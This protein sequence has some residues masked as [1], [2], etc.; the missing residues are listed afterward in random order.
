M[1]ILIERDLPA[2]QAGSESLAAERGLVRRSA[3][4]ERLSAVGPGNVIL[5]CAPAGSGKTLLVRSWAQAEGLSDRM[6]WVQVERGERDG[7]RFW[8]SVIDALARAVKEVRRVEP[9]PSFG[10]EAVVG[11]LGDDLGSL[12]EPALLV[13]DDLHE[14]QS[15][16]ALRWLELILS[17][18]TPLLR[19][20]LASREDPR[21]GLH[22]LRLAGE[23]LELR[24]P[25]LRFSLEETAEL[26]R[27]TGVTLSDGGLALLFERTEGWA[28]GLRLAA[29]LLT[30]H[31]DPERFVTEFSGSERTVAGYLVAEVLE[32]QPAD[33]REMLLRTSILERVSGSLADYLT[34][35]SGAERTLQALE[36]ANAFVTSLD[37]GRTWFR[38]HHLFSDLLQLELRRVAPASVGSLHRAAA[39]W[40]A[41]EGHIVEAIRHAQRARDWPFASRLLVDHHLDL[42]LDGRGG[43]VCGLLTAFPEDVVAADAELALVFATA[44]LV[45]QELEQSAGYVDLARRQVDSVQQE[46]RPRFDVLLALMTLV[47]ARWHG[48]IE[49]VQGSIRGLE[50]A[51]AALPGGERAMS[52][53][54]RSVARQNLGIAELWSARLDDARQNLEQA[55][56]LARRARRP[57]LEIPCLGHLGIAGPW[58]GLTLSEGLQLSE[59]AVRIT[60]AH[61]WSED[62]VIETA[63]A[64]GALA[65]L[66]LGRFDDVE[67]WLERAERSLHPEGEPGTELLLHHARG[68][69]RLAQG[70][71]EDALATFRA[72]ERT[73]ALLVD[74]HPFTVRTQA[75][76]LYTQAR[77]GQLAAAR[78][79]LADISEEDR[80]NAHFRIAAAVIHLADQEPE[81]A[82]DV[83]GPVIEGRVPTHHRPSAATEA[84]WLQAIA[85][86]QSGDPR[87]AEASLEQALD[88]AEPEGIVLPFI[89]APE[90]ELLERLPR[91]RTAH[92][93]L[94]RTIIGLLAGSSAPRRSEPHTLLEDLS[95]AE[96]R[97]V[98]YLPSNL[99]APEIAAELCVSPNT[100][101]THIRHI[102]A[103]LDSHDRNEAVARARELGLLARR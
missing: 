77:M 91:H 79:A 92:A 6:A 103:K 39:Q 69:L 53:A 34:G 46:R 63:L 4:F 20:V 85:C 70:N 22:R 19:V 36:D 31:P 54:L 64:T 84:Q 11:Q 55:L 99:K 43:T 59:Q 61:G 8:L 7:Q 90:R 68:L 5:L 50:A 51:L 32:R 1:A 73:Q 74:R 96:L 49:T 81:D 18:P 33:V 28:A 47:V 44:R 82:I 71:F 10:G 13:I 86:H 75:R 78:A 97:I 58:T 17:R 76:L 12:E 80:H 57:W 30:R 100:V 102:Y 60:D 27:A 87:E 42:T 40:L 15:A 35:G 89:L 9:A 94:L 25:D 65:L 98:R 16:A 88:L 14:L 38:Y 83:L 93:T 45:A 48:D 2:P 21:L 67:R 95:E 41:Q 37:V 24:A 23:L 66:W 101:R 72:A 62:P 56:T 29:I 26:L 3:L 52:D